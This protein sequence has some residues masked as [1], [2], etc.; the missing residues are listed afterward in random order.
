MVTPSDLI[1]GQVYNQQTKLHKILMTKLIFLKPGDVVQAQLF[2]NV[3]FNLE[4]QP[5]FIGEMGDV[6]GQAA[7][8]LTARRFFEDA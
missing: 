6:A 4:G 2:D 8:N 5:F 7:V 1:V 3:Q